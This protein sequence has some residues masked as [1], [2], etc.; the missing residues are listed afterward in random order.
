LAYTAAN[1]RYDNI[2]FGMAVRGGPSQ[3]FVVVDNI[4]LKF[5]SYTSDEGRIMIPAKINTVNVRLG[6]NLLFGYRE[7]VKALPPM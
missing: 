2:G 4:C 3:F 6:F 1:R 7:R 5:T